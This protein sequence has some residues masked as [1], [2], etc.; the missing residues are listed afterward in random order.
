MT[1][2]ERLR[3]FFSVKESPD[4]VEDDLRAVESLRETE[5]TDGGTPTGKSLTFEGDSEASDEDEIV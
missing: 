1:L 4:Q 5:P 2:R 3:L